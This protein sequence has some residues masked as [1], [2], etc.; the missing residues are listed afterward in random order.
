MV[1]PTSVPTAAPVRTSVAQWASPTTRNVPAAR[2]SAPPPKA[3]GVAEEYPC[4]LARVAPELTTAKA[5]AVSKEKNDL[6]R[7]DG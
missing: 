4:S 6:F 1:I 7:S 2:A 3:I 5:Q